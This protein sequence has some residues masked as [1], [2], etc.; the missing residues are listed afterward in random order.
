MSGLTLTYTLRAAL[1]F[2]ALPLAACSD[3]DDGGRVA[4]A[5]GPDIPAGI[6]EPADCQAQPR[7]PISCPAGTSAA[8]SCSRT[9][10]GRCE[11]AN[12]RCSTTLDATGAGTPA[13]GGADGG[14]D[15]TAGDA[16]GDADAGLEEAGAADTADAVD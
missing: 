14:M 11:W 1:V 2:L 12:A 3:D 16:G 6:C 5:A 15:G 8:F 10:T 13:D 4:D 7:P 9:L